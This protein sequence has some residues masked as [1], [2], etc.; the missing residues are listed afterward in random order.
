VDDATPLQRTEAGEHRDASGGDPEQCIHGRR[1]GDGAR[2]GRRVRSERARPDEEG[3][4]AE[5]RQTAADLRDEDREI[6]TLVASASKPDDRGPVA[7]REQDGDR[8]RPTART[9]RDRRRDHEDRGCRRGESGQDKQE[10]RGEAGSA[11]HGVIGSWR[12]GA[13]KG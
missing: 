1:P 3:N 9:V 2:A 6:A 10:R 12:V 4:A 7:D 8:D 11:V 5:D 13:G